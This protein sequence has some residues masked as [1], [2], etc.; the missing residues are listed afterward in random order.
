[1]NIVCF[2]FVFAIRQIQRG[3]SDCRVRESVWIRV[4]NAEW[5]RE[6]INIT[7][8]AVC[9]QFRDEKRYLLCVYVYT[10]LPFG[11]FSALDRVSNSMWLTRPGR[12]WCKKHSLVLFFWGLVY[13]KQAKRV[14]I[15]VFLN[16]HIVLQRK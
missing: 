6:H 12:I 2:H 11:I 3:K 4:Q 16:K 7:T 9:V 1:M 14:R 5:I 10:K 8:S 15:I 13:T